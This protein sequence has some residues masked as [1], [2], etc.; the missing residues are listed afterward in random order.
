MTSD[1]LSAINPNNDRRDIANN[2]ESRTEG[3]L[4]HKVGGHAVD[5]SRN[6]REYEDNKTRDKTVAYEQRANER[7]ANAASHRIVIQ[8]LVGGHISHLKSSLHWLN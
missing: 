8:R 6:P 5:L 1:I 3:I 4:S 7:S 2:S